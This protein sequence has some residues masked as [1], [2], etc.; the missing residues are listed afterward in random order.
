MDPIWYNVNEDGQVW[1]GHSDNH[2]KMGKM[3]AGSAIRAIDEYK[4]SVQFKEYKQPSNLKP[5]TSGYNQ[6][7]MRLAALSLEPYESSPD[8]IPNPIPTPTPLPEQYGDT[9][10]GAALRIFANFIRVNLLG[11]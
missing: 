11:R 3:L 10:L 2:Q 6:Y 5:L 1:S 8:P 7:W 4:G 9:Q